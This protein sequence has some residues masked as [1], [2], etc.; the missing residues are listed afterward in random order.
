MLLIGFFMLL[1]SLV[2]GRLKSVMNKYSKVQTSRGLSG[3]Q[4]AQEMLRD[5]GI[6]DVKITQGKG[7]LTDHYN[8]KSKTISLSPAIFEGQSI[9]A[10]AVAAHECGHAVQ[11]A[12]DYQWLQMRSNL[13]P[14]VNLGSK[15]YMWVIIAGLGMNFM[16]LAWGGIALFGFT[17]AFALV[18]LPVEYD[19]SN[20]ALAWLDRTSVLGDR[21]MSGA[22][23]ALNWAA[24]TYLVAAIASIAQLLY[25]I[26]QVQRR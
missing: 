14:M 23:T 11:H 25:W 20:R 8:P 22:K 5:H 24:R 21:E 15:F 6:H 1:G 4:I 7:F 12:T 13:V 2:G 9:A 10:A 19:A 18:T 16:G 17:T 26:A 3:A